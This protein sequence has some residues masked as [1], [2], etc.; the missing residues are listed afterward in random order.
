MRRTGLALAALVGLVA[1]AAASGATPSPDP[2]R[3]V[4]VQGSSSAAAARAV[5]QAGG[6]VLR[7]LDLVAGV[8]AELP[9]RAVLPGLT[10][11]PDA[12]LRP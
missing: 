12:A 8:S 11:T 9:A 7:R 1:A 5:E 2:A 4:I 3:H 10:V 6:R